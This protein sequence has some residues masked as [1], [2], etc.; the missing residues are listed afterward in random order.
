MNAWPVKAE[1]AHRTP[2]RKTAKC[3]VYEISHTLPAGLIE[4]NGPT[5]RT[6]AFVAHAENQVISGSNNLNQNCHDG[7]CECKLISNTHLR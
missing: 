3:T 7:D 6:D 2:V 4:V 1:F 5:A